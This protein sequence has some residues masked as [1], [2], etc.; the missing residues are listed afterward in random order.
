MKYRILHIADI[1]A[2]RMGSST[3]EDEVSTFG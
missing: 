3:R 2:P 1:S